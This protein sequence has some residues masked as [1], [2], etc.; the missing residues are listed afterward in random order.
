[1]YRQIDRE[2]VTGSGR[3]IMMEQADVLQ[4]IDQ[5]VRFLADRNT[6]SGAGTMIGIDA[7]LRV[8]QEMPARRFTIGIEMPLI[9]C[10]DLIHDLHAELIGFFAVTE[11]AV[12]AFLL[13]QD[14][15]AFRKT[16][17]AIHRGKVSAID[18]TF[19]REEAAFK[20]IALLDEKLDSRV[21]V[22]R[23]YI[24]YERHLALFEILNILRALG[25]IAQ[26]QS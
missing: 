7:D 24:H 14:V 8:Q 15:H 9:E 19:V 16:D 22:A 25:D 2:N 18:Q 21:H 1:M 12:A 10:S 23:H 20:E 26:N 4:M 17:H 3:K 6:R 13:H 5:F 11:A